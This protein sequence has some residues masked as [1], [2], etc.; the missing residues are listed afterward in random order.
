MQAKNGAAERSA[1][2]IVFMSHE[3]SLIFQEDALAF[4]PEVWGGAHF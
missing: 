3:L 1:P 2:L 4:S